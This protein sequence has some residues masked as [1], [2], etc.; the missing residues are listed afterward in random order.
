MKIIFKISIIGFFVFC[1]L[2]L[3]QLTNISSS[4]N[5]DAKIS[6]WTK[7]V[8]NEENYCI[9]IQITC[10]GDNVIDISPGEKGVYFPDNWIDLRPNNIVNK[11]C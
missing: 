5:N 7:A 10:K 6:K 11:W 1:V 9:D 4:I 2:T 3:I 8:C